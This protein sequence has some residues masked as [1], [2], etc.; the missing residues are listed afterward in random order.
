[1]PSVRLLLLREL[2]I[3]RL[4]DTLESEG[5]D[6]VD[7]NHLVKKSDNFTWLLLGLLQSLNQPLRK[8]SDNVCVREQESSFHLNRANHKLHL[9]YIFTPTVKPFL[10]KLKMLEKQVNC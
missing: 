4:W 9:L 8:D 1:M 2:E 5:A 6:S 10:R 7:I 3:F